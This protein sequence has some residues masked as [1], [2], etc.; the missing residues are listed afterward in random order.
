M[1]KPAPIH[2]VRQQH[3]ADVYDT[4][5]R[6]LMA[7][8]DDEELGVDPDVPPYPNREHVEFL[9]LVLGRLGPLEGKRVME[10]GCGS[11]AL[12]T[13]L[14]LRGATAVGIDVSVGMLEVAERRAAVNGVQRRVELVTGGVEDLDHPDGS[15]DAVIGNQVLHHLDLPR[16]MP[17]IARMLAPTGEACFVEPVLFLPRFAERLR[18]SPAVTRRFP[19]RRDTPDERSLDLEDIERVRAHFARSE[20]YPFQC[21]T[22]LQNFHHL[23]DRWFHRLERFDRALLARVPMSR[24]LCRYVV[25]V[26]AGLPAAADCNDRRVEGTS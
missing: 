5:A 22:R 8:I 21:T 16:A 25:L 13:Y 24:R 7:G 12:T 18:Y 3:E 26:L 9:D 19:S 1:S 14:A 11:G 17:N 6:D 4:R 15:Y 23:S 2:T 20:V 10:V